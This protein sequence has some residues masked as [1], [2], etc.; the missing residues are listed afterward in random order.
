MAINENFSL[1]RFIISIV[2]VGVTLVVGIYLMSTLSDT[3]KIDVTTTGT[4]TNETLTNVTNLTSTDFAILT[5]NSGAT[6]TLSNVYNATDGVV[7]TSGNY[8]QPTSCSI[9]ATDASQ[10]I[11]NDWNVTYTYSYTVSTATEASNASD[12]LVTALSN[13]TSW[14]SILVVVG[15]AVLVLSMLMNGL[16]SAATESQQVPYY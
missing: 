1:Q 16:G 12:D 13:G 6:C 4:N 5:T 3:M 11:G 10:Y 9:Q 8:T 2:I 14:I 7:I 15:F